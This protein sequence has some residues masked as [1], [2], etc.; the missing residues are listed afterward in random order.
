MDQ[1]IEPYL[2]F[3]RHLGTVPQSELNFN[4]SKMDVFVLPSLAEGMSSWLEAMACAVVP[5]V[6]ENCGYTDIIQNNINGFVVP[7]RSSYLIE[8][9]IKYLSDNP[10]ILKSIRERSLQTAIS[11]S[12]DKYHASIQ[13]FYHSISDV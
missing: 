11:L 2:K 3:I 8:E 5:I 13:D 6:S 7:I 1:L 12:W 10:A 4:Y 9:K